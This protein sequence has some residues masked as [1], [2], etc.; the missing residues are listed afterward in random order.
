MLCPRHGQEEPE[1]AKKRTR[2]K[3]TAKSTSAEQAVAPKKTS[4]KGQTANG[5]AASTGGPRGG[6]KAGDS[7][8]GDLQAAQ[9]GGRGTG[10]WQTGSLGSPDGEWETVSHKKS[11]PRKDKAAGAN[12]ANVIPGGLGL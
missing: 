1:A 6:Q 9:N 8:G 2:K 4:A 12:D 10:D 3:K 7:S 5:S 11:K